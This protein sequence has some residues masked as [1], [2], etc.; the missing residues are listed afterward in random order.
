MMERAAEYRER[1]AKI[2]KAGGLRWRAPAGL[3]DEIVAWSKSLQSAGHGVG[4]IATAI[5]LSESALRRWMTPSDNHG[6]LQRVRVH[7]GESKL[8]GGS[9]SIQ[10][11]SGYRLEGVTID[12]AIEALRRL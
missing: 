8:T 3:R 12:Q 9:L 7:S 5:G 11:P 1:L 10:S 6:E 4:V 2:R